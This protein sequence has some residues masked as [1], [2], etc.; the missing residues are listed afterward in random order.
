MDELTTLPNIG[1]VVADKL[2]EVGIDSPQAL[3]SA[4]AINAFMR[5]RAIDSTACIHMLM[6]LQ[7]AID[8]IRWHSLPPEK[9]QELKHF[10]A[11]LK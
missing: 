10:F 5:I 4:G 9:K 6:G 3:R 8:G 2:I 7:G 1:K 11:T